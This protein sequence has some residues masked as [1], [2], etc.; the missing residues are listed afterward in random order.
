MTEAAV[1]NATARIRQLIDLTRRLTD[2][3][4][5]EARAFE[6]RRPQD[7]MATLAETQDLANA[8]RRE[9]AQ[10]K[11]NPASVAAAPLADRKALIGATQAFEE[12]L[13]RHAF[14]VEAART[15]S[16]GLV[17]TIAAEVAGLR[18]NPSA[19]GA[20]GRANGGDTRAVAYNRTT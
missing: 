1:L 13:T 5:E 17:R 16:E 12:I 10:L 14:A 15:I 2:R 9:S 11:A 6:A 3:L 20:S 4:T 18:G 19:Y 8:Y 7:A